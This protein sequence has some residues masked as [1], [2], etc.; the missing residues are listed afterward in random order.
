[1]GTDIE[2]AAIAAALGAFA[3]RTPGVRS[4]MPRSGSG[5]LEGAVVGVVSVAAAGLAASG[6]Q[7]GRALAL[8][9]P[10]GPRRDS[11]RPARTSRRPP[12]GRTVRA[13]RRSSSISA[14]PRVPRHG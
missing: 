11:W 8:R 10:L 6:R 1:M 9:P 2:A 14:G 4:P 7:G 3:G 13:P 5:S 12:L